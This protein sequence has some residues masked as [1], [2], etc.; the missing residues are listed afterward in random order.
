MTWKA[1]KTFYNGSEEKYTDL[2]K[3]QQNRD[4]EEKQC[5][6]CTGKNHLIITDSKMDQVKKI[7]RESQI[8]T[9]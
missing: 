7:P 1:R 5:S 6:I 4:E 2:F 3:I 9:F 8:D